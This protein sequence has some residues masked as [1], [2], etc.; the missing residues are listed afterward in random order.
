MHW[1][2]IAFLVSILVSLYGLAFAPMVGFL[3]SP[4]V[5]TIG[6]AIARRM[7][8]GTGRTML[9]DARVEIGS[10]TIAAVCFLVATF[11]HPTPGHLRSVLAV[12]GM[13]FAFATLA[14]LSV[15]MILALANALRKKREGSLPS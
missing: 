12:L 15:K 11:A 5:I 1:I 14:I 6:V 3:M 13:V 4:V 10:A 2:L 7:P 9:H 8:T